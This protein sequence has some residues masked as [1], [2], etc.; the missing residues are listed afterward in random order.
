MVQRSSPAPFLVKTYQL[1]DDSTTDEM[2]SWNENG[3]GFVVWKTADFARDLLPYSFKHNNFS[4]FVRQLNTYGFHKTLPDK[5][6]FANDHFKRGRKDLL[7]QIHRR[8]T[9]TSPKQ[10][11]DND[12]DGG[13]GTDMGSTS[14]SS[15]EPNNPTTTVDRPTSVKLLNLSGENEKLR[16]ENNVLTTEIA[17]VKRQCDGLVA[18]LKECVNVSPEEISN[19]VGGDTVVGGG[20]VDDDEQ[21]GG[22]CF[23]LFGVVL[24]DGKKK[25]GCFGESESA[26]GCM[27]KI[28]RRSDVRDDVTVFHGRL[29]CIM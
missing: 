27:K 17:A 9:M 26:G 20:D 24:K 3:D 21:D 1:V 10:K 5:W 8:K 29:G 18:L 11:S 28:K 6:E 25:R 16:K 12:G 22:D 15:P 4:S 19:I 14:T 2:I 13:S 7:I 23:R